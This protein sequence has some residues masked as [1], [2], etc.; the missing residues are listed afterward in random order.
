MVGMFLDARMKGTVVPLTI[1]GGQ[2]SRE[3]QWDPAR[4]TRAHWVAKADLVSVVQAK[5]QT[6][7]LKVAPALKLAD[8]LRKELENFRV[9]VSKGAN[10]L[11]AAREGEHD[12]MVL[13][14]AMALWLA[15]RPAVRS[16]WVEDPFAEVEA[17]RQAPAA[18][19]HRAFDPFRRS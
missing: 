12:D 8:V 18:P 5:L 10:E 6:G 7:R 1:T 3:D 15:D 9:R 13:S 14:L 2:G 19:T 16:I 17:D 4:G 11:Y